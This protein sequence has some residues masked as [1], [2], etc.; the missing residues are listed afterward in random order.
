MLFATMSAIE[1]DI[2]RKKK[3]NVNIVA[4]LKEFFIYLLI[5]IIKGINRSADII[6]RNIKAFS[7][8]NIPI[9][10]VQNEAVPGNKFQRSKQALPNWLFEKHQP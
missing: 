1:G 4:T 10:N 8:C 9:P 7:L 2:A 6:V 5:K 3:I